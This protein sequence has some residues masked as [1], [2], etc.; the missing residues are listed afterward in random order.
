MFGVD[1]LIVVGDV[2]REGARLGHKL[3]VD[4]VDDRDD[5]AILRLGC[6]GMRASLFS[7]CAWPLW[8]S[9]AAPTELSAKRAD[10][11]I[12]AV[13]S[14]M[15]FFMWVKNRSKMVVRFW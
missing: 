13:A 7:P 11:V 2:E 9:S 3:V 12:N 4:V 5:A 14:F 10:A 15:G 8:S 6:M 1:R